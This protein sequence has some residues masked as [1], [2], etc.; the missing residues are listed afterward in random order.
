MPN[1]PDA[2]K[3]P[4]QAR[5]PVPTLTEHALQSALFAWAALAPKQRP[6]LAMLVAIPNGGARG[7]N[8]KSRAIRG[9]ALKAEGV[10]KG[11]PDTALN[12]ARGGYNGLFIEMKTPIGR[13]SPEQ[14]DWIERLN[15]CGNYATVCR[16]WTEAKAVIENYLDGRL[17]ES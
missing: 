17:N 1:T 5:H 15:A 2:V 9:N 10:K 4:Q 7:D 16:G 12:V 13:V 11:Y 3:P 8:P 6:E 14:K